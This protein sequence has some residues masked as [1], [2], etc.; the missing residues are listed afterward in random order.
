MIFV[1]GLAAVGGFL[2]P[3][4]HHTVP[5]ETS[6]ARRLD[7]LWCSCVYQAGS[8]PRSGRKWK[9]QGRPDLRRL[10]LTIGRADARDEAERGK[11]N[12]IRDSPASPGKTECRVVPDLS[13]LMRAGGLDGYGP[14]RARVGN[15]VRPHGEWTHGWG[16]LTFVSVNQPRDVHPRTVFRTR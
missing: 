5:E 10:E 15:G 1:T 11:P 12:A 7:E 16:P 3:V 9:V 6:C 8:A 4:P 14:M 2:Y 13:A